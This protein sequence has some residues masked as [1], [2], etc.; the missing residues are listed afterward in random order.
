[1]LPFLGFNEHSPRPIQIL[2]DVIF[3]IPTGA[4]THNKIEFASAN[5][6]GSV[7]KVFDD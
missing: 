2:R 5:F 4:R 6:V 7:V 1:M 3:T